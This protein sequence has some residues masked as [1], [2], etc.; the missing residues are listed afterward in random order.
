MTAEFLERL[1]QEAEAKEREESAFRRDSRRRLEGLEAE[2]TRLFRRYNFLNDLAAAA[3]AASDADTAIAVQL[4]RASAETGWSEARTGYEEMRDRL[5]PLAQAICAAVRPK[6]D[7]E[8]PDDA[9]DAAKVD[10]VTAFDEF[11]SWYRG[12]FG[13]AFLDLL[14]RPAPSFQPLVDF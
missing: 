9:S 4:A 3:A 14:G 6:D 13:E 8:R 10:A 5:R 2:R 1:R 7:L 11:E 12:K